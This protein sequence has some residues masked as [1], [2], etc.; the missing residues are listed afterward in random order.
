MCEER[1]KKRV[2]QGRVPLFASFPLEVSFVPFLCLLSGHHI[3]TFSRV[4]DW[5]RVRTRDGAVA[6]GVEDLERL[7]DLRGK[8]KQRAH[9]H[10]ATMTMP[11]T[12]P[13]RGATVVGGQAAPVLYC[14]WKAAACGS[15]RPQSREGQRVR[16]RPWVKRQSSGVQEWVC[17]YNWRG[18][19]GQGGGEACCP[20]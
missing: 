1:E 17:E 3:S 11:P 2:W 16:G 12:M 14:S 18:G 7:D 5:R 13:C 9:A 10:N 19:T 6:V 4:C 20:A 15:L 8:G